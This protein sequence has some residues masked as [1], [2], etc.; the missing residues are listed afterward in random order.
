MPKMIQL[1]NVP[2][3]VHAVLRARAANEGKSLSEYLKQQVA[4]IAR[5]P[6]VNEVLDRIETREP[7]NVTMKS[8]VDLI[9][10]DRD[11]H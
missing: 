9:R 8:I 4:S 2:D 6:T 7:V 11:S 5:R 1:R 3:D 10:E